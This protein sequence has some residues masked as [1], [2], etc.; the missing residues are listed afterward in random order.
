MEMNAKKKAAAGASLR[1]SA[2]KAF[3]A[4]NQLI[5]NKMVLA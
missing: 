4:L 1:N 3:L 2:T 5:K